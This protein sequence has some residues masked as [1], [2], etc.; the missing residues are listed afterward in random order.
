[1]SYFASGG[2]GMGAFSPME[3]GWAR[4]AASSA[5]FRISSRLKG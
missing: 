5:I 3:A 1:M 2:G 4:L